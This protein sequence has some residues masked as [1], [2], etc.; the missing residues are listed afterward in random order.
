MI[1]LTEL[2]GWLGVDEDPLL[3]LLEER[4]VDFVEGRT[5]RYFGVDQSFT[6]VL[7]GTGDDTLWLNEEP[8]SL[9]SVEWRGGVGDSYT[10][11]ATGDADG[12]E[13][14]GR[15]VR[16]NDGYAWQRSREYRVIYTHGYGTAAEPGEIRQLVLD[17]TKL[18]WDARDT[19]LAITSERK[20]GQSYTRSD[21]TDLAKLLP[22]A[23]DTLALWTW[24][25]KA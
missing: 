3:L 5:G 24:R 19:N 1:D 18:A 14:L 23:A 9:T 7:A 6:E 13:L 11:I 2:A 25:R 12:W 8:A 22:W 4:A 15:R 20:G 16:R 21:M 10:A 17:L